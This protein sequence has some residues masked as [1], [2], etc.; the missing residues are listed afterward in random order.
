MDR[1]H[2]NVGK[3]I[4]PNNLKLKQ[5]FK[6]G[7]I[8]SGKI[9]REYIKVIKSFNHSVSYIFSNSNRINAKDLA[10]NNNAKLLINLKDIYF[11]KDV[12]FWIVC[13]SWQNL[14]KIFFAI[15]KVNKPV[16]FEKSIAMRASELKKIQ[17]QKKYGSFLKKLSFAYNRNHYDYMH[18]LNL[19]MIKNEINYGYAYLYDPLNRLLKDKKISKKY[20]TKYISSHW[21]SLILKIFK[22]AKFKIKNLKKSSINLK[23]NHQKISLYLKSKKNEFIFD[24]FYFPNLPKNH[25]ITF[26]LKNKII[27]ISPIEQ[28]IIYEGLEK[29][30]IGNQNKYI[31]KIKTIKV[32]NNYKPGFRY[33]YYNFI[34]KHFFKKDIGLLTNIDD[35]IKIYEIS[36]MLSINEN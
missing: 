7:I 13:T 34:N 4:F 11:I 30:Q 15:A 25:Q 35:L 17:T 16:L 12:D 14:K 26:F 21:I 1:N 18:F 2:L 29:K 31:P 23:L 9:S 32:N 28:I 22:S 5:K 8:G 33:Q 27:E 36:E 3:I 19:L 6:V 10:K 24:I 20:F